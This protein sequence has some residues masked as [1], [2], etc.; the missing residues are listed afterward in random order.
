[1]STTIKTAFTTAR[2]DV[3]TRRFQLS[4][5]GERYAQLLAFLD[6]T[7]ARVHALTPLS[8]QLSLS[9]VDPDGDEC[10]INS[11]P[12]LLE[13][14][15]CAAEE[16]RTLKVKVK[17]EDAVQVSR[18]S[19]VASSRADEPVSRQGSASVSQP[20]KAAASAVPEDGEDEYVTVQ[21]LKSFSLTAP[22]DEEEEVKEEPATAAAPAPV[23]ASPAKSPAPVTVEDITEE[24]RLEDEV[25]SSIN[26][27]LRSAVPT[28][29][30]TGAATPAPA[31]GEESKDSSA[32]G[33]AVHTNVVCDGCSASPLVGDR[34][35]VRLTPPP[36]RIRSPICC[37]LCSSQLSHIR[38]VYSVSVPAQ[39]S[40]CPDFDL[41]SSCEAAGKHPASHTLLKIKVAN[42][43]RGGHHWWRRGGLGGPHGGHPFGH[44]G[45]HGPHGHHLGGPGP[46]GPAPH[47]LGGG[48]GG[49][50]GCRWREGG[51]GWGRGECEVDGVDRPKAAFIGDV[52]LADGVRVK[53]GQVLQKVWQVKNTGDKPWPA[54][55]RLHF[56]GG[57]VTPAPIGSENPAS[58]SDAA[59]V[60]V[61]APGQVINIALDIQTPNEEGRF[62]GTFRLIT[63]DGIRFGP[64]IW[65]DLDVSNSEAPAAPAA[66]PVAPA[67]STSTSQVGPSAPAAAQPATQ[68]PRAAIREVLHTVMNA[69]GSNRSG[70]PVQNILTAIQAAVSPSHSAA[71][72]A[73]AAPVPTAAP[74]GPFEYQTALEQVHAMGFE[75]QEERVK[76]LLIRYRGN[77]ARTLNQL[78][79]E[80]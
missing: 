28:D 43:G 59:L 8:T 80:Q 46:H 19:S 77:V 52:T 2:G 56:V 1:M 64:R 45:P 30:A 72:E 7:Y 57:D 69:L 42:G 78:L 70:N 23:A 50:G 53:P 20:G 73:S 38:P 37:C 35:K 16:G 62:R 32:S 6:A 39:C 22:R 9:Y 18:P 26:D 68:D 5:D 41:C 51:R 66:P 79:T 49:P 11:E 14:I 4:A 60:P 13:A 74:A 29:A 54:G 10:S 21:A 67:Q 12:E 31:V 76:A 75:G 36:L 65:L 63:P 71:S 61:A 27:L 55:T 47:W 24:E 17:A 15:R 25:V 44:H 40:V 58:W 3:D 48:R 34:Y 33:P